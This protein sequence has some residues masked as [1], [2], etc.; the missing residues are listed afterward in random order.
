MSRQQ[1]AKRTF[2]QIEEKIERDQERERERKGNK[3][4]GRASFARRRF[5]FFF[6]FLH[7]ERKDKG[8]YR[9]TVHRAI[10]TGYIAVDRRMCELYMSRFISFCI[11]FVGIIYFAS[12]AAHTKLRLQILRLASRVGIS[13]VH[14]K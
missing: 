13:S 9:V 6:M 1:L 7:V 3:G 10:K 8:E 4:K 11:L 12:R 2:K 14:V 5:P